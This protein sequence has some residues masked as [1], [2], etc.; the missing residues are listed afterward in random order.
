MEVYSTLYNEAR[1][2]K[3]LFFQ[4]P[5]FK[6]ICTFVKLRKMFLT[7]VQQTNYS[8]LSM[9]KIMLK[10]DDW[11]SVLNRFFTGYA[12]FTRILGN[13][14]MSLE[15]STKQN[16]KLKNFKESL[17]KISMTTLLEAILY[18]YSKQHTYYEESGKH[19]VN[20]R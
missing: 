3:E 17:S 19:V 2:Y 14:K 7:Q 6:K 1:F 16:A 5:N 20:E 4:E 10:F 18:E 13:V 8:G 11:S 15:V 12:N 9:D